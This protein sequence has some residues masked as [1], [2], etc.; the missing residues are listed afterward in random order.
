[1][2]HETDSIDI[3]YSINTVSFS[4]TVMPNYANVMEAR[5]VCYNVSKQFELDVGCLH[6]RCDQHSGQ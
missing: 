5:C 4:V 3:H 1:M 6:I 2:V